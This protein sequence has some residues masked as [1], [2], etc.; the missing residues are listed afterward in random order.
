[1]IRTPTVL[2]LGAGASEEY[3]LPLGGELLRKI[4]ADIKN[5]SQDAHSVY[6]LLRECSY[7]DKEVRDF[8]EQLEAGGLPSVD[9][10]LERRQDLVPIGK[11]AIAA[12]LLGREN[13]TQLF[14][15]VRADLKIKTRWY[16]H[17]WEKL[18]VDADGKQFDSND[19]S[20]V[21]FNYDRSLEAFLYDAMKAVYP[22]DVDR[23]W[24]E[25]VPIVHV[26]GSLGLYNPHENGHRDYSTNFTLAELKAAAAS[27]RIVSDPDDDHVV[28]KANDLL[29]RAEKVC[30]LGFHFHAANV[31]KLTNGLGSS[32]KIINGT[33]LGMGQGIRAQ[34]LQRLRDTRSHGL[35]KHNSIE[36]DDHRRVLQF[37]E[38]AG[39]LV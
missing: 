27:I 23:L 20:I 33:S 15:R 2:V 31:H 18:V 14:D 6:R 38:H 24:P 34:V 3:G 35:Q 12:A 16:E 32:A 30:F 5:A 10:F 37:L 11:A 21:T 26:H 19:L 1:M 7:P 36:L 29:K 22:N 17:L 25:A 39:V 4:L 28:N 9:I 13:P 8:A